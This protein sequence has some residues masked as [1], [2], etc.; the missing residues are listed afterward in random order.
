M[1]QEGREAQT[2][3]SLFSAHL[4][5]KWHLTYFGLS[6][7]ALPTFPVFH[8]GRKERTEA[9]GKQCRL[10]PDFDQGLGASEE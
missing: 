9:K 1:A 2:S 4:T 8:V 10:K 3:D 6:S 7:A 5:E